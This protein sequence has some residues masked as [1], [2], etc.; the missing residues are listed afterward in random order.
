MGT[1]CLTFVY[2]NNVPLVNVYRQFDGYPSGHGKDLSKFM[3]DRKII[4]GFNSEHSSMFYSNGMG[5]FAAG[6]VEHLK[7]KQ[8]GNIYL[9][10]V[11]DTKW[12]QD[13]EYH[14]HIDSVVVKTYG[15][16][17]MFKGSWEDF[18]DFCDEEDE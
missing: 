17:I 11:N 15:G 7:D 13:Y 8:L 1:R 12:G 6:L 16:H 5:C 3:K 9:Y 10:S 14:I 2:D 4:N 18:I